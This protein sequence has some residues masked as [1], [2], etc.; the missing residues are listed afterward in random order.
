MKCVHKYCSAG[1]ITV[2]RE[3]EDE[4]GDQSK[5][6]TS[7]L[8]PSG[9]EYRKICE[10]LNCHSLESQFEHRV[11]M[12][13]KCSDFI[14]PELD[15]RQTRPEL[16]QQ[17][18][19]ESPVKASSERIQLLQY[20]LMSLCGQLLCRSSSGAVYLDCMAE[21]CYDFPMDGDDYLTEPESLSSDG[22]IIAE[23]SLMRKRR[24]NAISAQC[25]E[26]Q[27][28][29]KGGVSRKLCIMKNCHG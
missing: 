23:K 15:E 12:V 25:I 2:P 13:A 6:E 16:D 20:S 17:P 7:E 3:L 27:C 24:V 28:S 18:D 10:A 9:D 26:S 11:C 4:E 19:M 29:G 14:S 1:L 21:N 5:Y 8:L 22:S